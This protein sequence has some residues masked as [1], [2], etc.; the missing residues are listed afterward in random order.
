M[1]GF[2]PPLPGAAP[3]HSTIFTCFQ[4]Q[5]C[6]ESSITPFPST[7][8]RRGKGSAQKEVGLHFTISCTRKNADKLH[9][10]ES[11]AGYMLLWKTALSHPATSLQTY[12]KHSLL[13]R[14]PETGRG[15]SR[16]V[17]PNPEFWRDLHSHSTV[18]WEC[19]DAKV[20]VVLMVLQYGTVCSEKYSWASCGCSLAIVYMT[21]PWGSKNVQEVWSACNNDQF[22]YFIIFRKVRL[23]RNIKNKK[24]DTNNKQKSRISLCL[25]NEVFLPN[26]L[27]LVSSDDLVRRLLGVRGRSGRG[28]QEGRRRVVMS[29]GR[30]YQMGRGGGG[31]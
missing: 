4:V 28:L 22:H 8:S 10:H 26:T 9:A 6:T 14:R 19:N 27:Q 23:S 5:H 2:S 13:L 11:L 7:L 17:S 15:S 20:I 18:E 1:G 29:S 16:L 25:M 30:E 12:L 21:R 24:S 3:V 31:S